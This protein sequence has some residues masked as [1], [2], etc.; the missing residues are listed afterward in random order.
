MF[1]THCSEALPDY[2]PL[3]SAYRLTLTGA[4]D[5]KQGGRR[6]VDD[7]AR[8]DSERVLA[9]NQ[10][11]GPVPLSPRP[12]PPLSVVSYAIAI[13]SEERKSKRNNFFSPI[14]RTTERWNYYQ[15]KAWPLSSV[16]SCYRLFINRSFAFCPL[17][18]FRAFVLRASFASSISIIHHT[19]TRMHK[20][21]DSSVK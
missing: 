16:A 8:A 5:D 6:N 12:R 1:K 7:E 20:T 13:R 4:H 18:L 10:S 14:H 3:S 11:H 21:Q 19:H 9:A 17:L 15:L 2:Q